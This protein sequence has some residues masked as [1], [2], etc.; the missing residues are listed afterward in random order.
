MK[1]ENQYIIHFKG[2]KEGFHAFE[3]IISKPF[4]EEYLNLDI[5]D[6]NIGVKVYLTKKD[7]FME[8]KIELIGNIQ[9][10]CDRC[11]EY[12]SLS[13][14]YNG[15]LVI[16]LSETEEEA[17]DEVMVLHPDEDTLKLKHYLYECISLAIPMR[18]VHP[19]LPDGKTGCN[20]EMISKLKK[21]LIK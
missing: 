20:T 21:H 12:F 18:K 5:P 3:F 9:V 10:Q 19:E 11:L 13:I 4:F 15:H 8:L 1:F 17:D 14:D 6:G 7:H 2:L 16:K